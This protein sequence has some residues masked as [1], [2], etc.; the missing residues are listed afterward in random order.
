MRNIQI[1]DCTLRDGGYVND[2]R[3]GKN[4]IARIIQKLTS[5][6][7]DI[8]EC[9]FLEECDY[10]PDCSFYNHV[11]Q[12]AEFLPEDRRNTCYV[13]MTR[14]GKYPIES[15]PPHDGRSIDGIRVSF[16]FNEVEEGIA[17]C[18]QIK[19][20]G[21]KVFIQPVGTSSYCDEDLLSLIHLVNE[22]KPYSFYLV[23]TLGLMHRE[24]VMRFFYLINHNL[25]KAIH[26][27][28][29]SHNNLQLSYSNCQSLA[30]LESD[31][32]MSLDASVYG[33]G[34]GAGNLNTE[35]MANY[36]NTHFQHRYEIE[37]L[38]EI[39]DEHI[40]KIKAQHNW[41]YTVPHYLAAINGCHPNYAAYLSSKQRLTV[42]NISTILRS[43]EPE[44]RSLFDKALAEK[45]YLEFQSREIDD[46]H[47]IKRLAERIAERPVLVLAPGPSLNE[48][49]KE[50]QRFVKSSGCITISVGFIPQFVDCDFTFIS[51][52]KRYHT[53]FNPDHRKVNLIHTSNIDIQ[54][55]SKL[56][57]NYS[58]LLCEDDEI[59]DNTAMM[60][61]NLLMKLNPSRVYLAGLD[62]YREN[63]SNF[64]Q[65]RLNM[66]EQDNVRELNAAMTQ[67]IKE[68]SNVMPIEFLTPSLYNNG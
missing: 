34:R 48:Y 19:Q 1:L 58:S 51:N 44:K 16:H 2:W 62:G 22:L 24:D 10:D 66:S 13:A 8:I 38:L 4:A 21:Y 6:G 31:R 46:R 52:L 23:D 60:L 39:I 33:M 41:G 54:E 43:I 12:I 68:L 42:K 65:E 28:F 14:L 27:G 37:P 20:K 50:I 36:L 47:N 61:L 32:V 64:Y 5:S 25:D 63:E 3:F 30:S 26:M 15:L 35:L 7:V 18:H 11:D 53:T 59:M 49:E 56:V 17:Y 9:G 40:S 55:D 57:V 67:R 45:K 29:H